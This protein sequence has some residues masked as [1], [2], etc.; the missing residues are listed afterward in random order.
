MKTTNTLWL[1][2]LVMFSSV[3]MAQVAV[4]LSVSPGTMVCDN[5]PVTFTATITGCP[6]AYNITWKDGA[7]I[8]DTTYSPSITW[9]STLYSGTRQIWCTVDC[10]PNGNANSSIITMTVDDC[11]GIEEYQNGTQITLYPN[12]SANNVVL[13]VTK[14]RMLPASVSVFDINGK[15]VTVSYEITDKL[16]TL[17]TKH[18]NEGIY[19]YRISDKD[20]EKTATGRFAIVR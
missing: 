14:L 12:P 5:E 3:A 6:S 13:D 8:V 2:A 19:Y 15:A 4:T 11:S 20:R 9:T 18:L 17:D 16:A 10:N 1:I 7:F